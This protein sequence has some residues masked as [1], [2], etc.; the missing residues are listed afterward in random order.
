MKDDRSLGI[1]PLW[2]ENEN[3]LENYNYVN[4]FVIRD[5]LLQ[6]YSTYDQLFCDI[7]VNWSHSN[8]HLISGMGV[9]D[10]AFCLH[11]YNEV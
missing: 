7:P 2:R 4:N 1:A 11:Q 6:K 10:E 3:Q 9:S 5:N 8:L